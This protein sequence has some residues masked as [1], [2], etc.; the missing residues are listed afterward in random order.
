MKPPIMPSKPKITVLICALNEEDNLQHVLPR[1]PEWVDEV[2]L[3]DGHSTDNTV[4]VAKTLRPDINVVTQ[5]GEGKGD[6]LKCGIEHA[7]GDIIVTLDAD[8]AT[9]PSEMDKFIE[10][11][12]NG[13]DFAKGSRLTHG[14]PRGMPRHR[15]LGNRVLAVTSNILHGTRYTDICSGYNAFW[16]GSFQRLSPIHDGFEMEQE[17]LVKIRKARLKVVEVEHHAIGRSSGV[18]KVSDIRQGLVD[19]MVIIKERFRD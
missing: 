3:V 14:R 6:A 9:D 4:A 2:V 5:P 15:W 19:L 13:Y 10:P 8:G 11:L 12:L 18:S 16:K 1:I 7:A 17:L